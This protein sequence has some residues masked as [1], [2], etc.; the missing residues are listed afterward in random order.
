LKSQTASTARRVLSLFYGTPWIQPDP[1]APLSQKPLAD[2]IAQLA[3]IPEGV[4]PRQGT[5]ATYPA[6]IP[7]LIGV[8]DRQYLDHTGLQQHRSIVDLMRY[9]AI[10]NFIEEVTDYDGFRPVTGN[11]SLPDVDT[12]ARESDLELYALARYIYSLQPPP[13][14][15]I[16]DATAER[17]QKV[18]ERE[19]CSRCHT[20]PLYTNNMLTPALG[21]TVPDEDRKKYRI[22]DVTVGTDPFLATRTRRGT[23]YYKVPSLKGV[24]YRGPFEHNGSVAT[25]EDWFDPRRLSPDYVPTG[26]RGYGAPARAIKGHPFGL[27]LTPEDKRALI[28]FLKTL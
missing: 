16:F 23:G 12:L 9:D 18:F 26:Y 25:L 27:A 17:G 19:R 15:N 3:S 14:P 2:S 6:Q 21:F 7:D 1:T 24:W 4:N 10:N 28:A 5:S 20:P 11:A 8:Q 13:N 22:M